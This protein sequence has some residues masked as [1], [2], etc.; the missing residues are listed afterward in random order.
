MIIKL[1][2]LSV[3]TSGVYLLI[4]IDYDYKIVISDNKIILTDYKIIMIIIS[5]DYK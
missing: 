4:I 1:L 2:I 3:F 5:A